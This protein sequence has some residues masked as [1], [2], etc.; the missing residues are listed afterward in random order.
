MI[1]TPINRR[2]TAGL[3]SAGALLLVALAATPQADA[4]TL[5]AC[6]KKNGTARIFTNKP[7][8][9]KHETK[10]SWN[11]EGPPGEKRDERRERH[12]RHEGTN[13]TSG[14]NGADLTSHTPLPSGQSESGWFA[15]GGGSSTSKFVAEGISFSQPLSTPIA[16]GHAVFNKETKPRLTARV[17]GKQTPAISVCTQRSKPA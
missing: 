4:T 10:L 9:K 2:T 5:Y 12:Q 15:L 16:E 17:S 3:A 6:V 13:G 8:C 14:T 1:S 11:N 7:K